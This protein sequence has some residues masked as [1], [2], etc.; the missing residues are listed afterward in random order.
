MMG[1]HTEDPNSTH[2]PNPRFNLHSGPNSEP[3]ITSGKSSC[4]S[5]RAHI[6][7]GVGGIGQGERLDGKGSCHVLGLT[8]ID[9]P[10]GDE[11]ESDLGAGVE[12]LESAVVVRENSLVG[13][14]D[15]DVLREGEVNGVVRDGEGGE[16]DGV[17]GDSGISGLENCEEHNKDNDNNKD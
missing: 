12:E 13:V 16:L 3:V 15:G 4:E 6:N 9:F 14:L 7:G 1:K 8:G 10:G 5:I 11:H 17:D 2:H